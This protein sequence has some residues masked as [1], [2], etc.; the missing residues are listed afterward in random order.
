MNRELPYLIFLGILFAAIVVVAE[1]HNWETCEPN[2]QS[3]SIK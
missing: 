3:D 2:Y 1:Y